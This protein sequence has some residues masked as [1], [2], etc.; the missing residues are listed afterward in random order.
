MSDPLLALMLWMECGKRGCCFT[1][2]SCLLSIELVPP[3]SSRGHGGQRTQRDDSSSLVSLLHMRHGHTLNVH[4]F[5]W[6]WDKG[7]TGS[8]EACVSRPDNPLYA[9]HLQCYLQTSFSA[10][11]HI[12]LPYLLFS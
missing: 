11:Y 4:P 12:T 6:S 9:L 7:Y 2:L 8:S 5:C 1:T 3:G 10:L